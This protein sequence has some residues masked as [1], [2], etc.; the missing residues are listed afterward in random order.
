MMIKE[1]KDDYKYSDISNLA[2][3][4]TTDILKDKPELVTDVDLGLVDRSV[5]EK[6]IVKL[7]DKKGSGILTD[8]TRITKNVM[9]YMFGYGPIQEYIEDED[10]SDIDF[11]RYDY[12]IC[13]RN[14]KK[15]RMKIRFSNPKEF[16]DFCRLIIVRNGGIINENDSHCR[17]SDDKYRLR[18]NV[19]IA[20]RNFESPSLI[21]RKHRLLPYNLKDLV[22]KDMLSREI[23][24]YLKD[25]MK[26]Q[27]RI[28]ISG[29]GASGKTTLLRALLG[30]TDEFERILICE[31][32]SELYCENINFISQRIKKRQYGGSIVTLNDLIRDGLT[33]SLDGYCIGE[34]TGKEAWSFVNAGY[35]DHRI[36][37]TI[38]ATSS[39]DSLTRIL[40]LIEE[41]KVNLSEETLKE[42]IS[43][44]ID[45]LIY[46]KDFKISEI[47]EIK[48]FDDSEVI[49]EKIL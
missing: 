7:C 19:S 23:Y 27:D 28:L 45:I 22:H 8:R 12:G 49:F 9:D 36:F 14:G 46:M 29:K 48:G 3:E 26:G 38:H 30:E 15:E 6:E 5:L 31:S 33:M 10:I 21:I 18:I 20:P 37:G 2:R 24:S 43:S 32:D 4:I 44:S 17:V 34:I 11:L 16:E 13:K 41:N 42:I 35:T 40:A 1:K 39:K 25:K 47:L